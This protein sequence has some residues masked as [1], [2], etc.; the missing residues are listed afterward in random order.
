MKTL[1]K[2]CSVNDCGFQPPTPEYSWSLFNGQPVCP[3]HFERLTNPP[4]NALAL[5]IASFHA[6]LLKLG[7]KLGGPFVKVIAY[8]ALYRV[9]S[10]GGMEAVSYI[11]YEHMLRTAEQEKGKVKKRGTQ[12][13]MR[14]NKRP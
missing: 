2:R 10:S 6:I 4:V 3:F 8:Y 11:C 13:G 14:E 9:F 7:P 5:R 12:T 1:A